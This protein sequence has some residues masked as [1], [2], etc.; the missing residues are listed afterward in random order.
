MKIRLRLSLACVGFACL[1]TAAQAQTGFYVTGGVGALWRQDYSRSTLFNNA[2][3]TTAQGSTATSYDP[4]PVFSL[5]VGWRV[6]VLPIRIEAEAGYG[7][8]TV[9]KA[10]I[11]TSD[12]AFAGL[13]GA[14]LHA[15]SGGGRDRLTA[16]VS[17]YYDLPLPGPVTPYVGAGFGYWR[18]T[19]ENTVFSDASGFPVLNARG[20]TVNNV[21]LLAEVGAAVR[22]V[23]FSRWSVAPAYRFQHLFAAGQPGVNEHIFKLAVRYDF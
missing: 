14:S 4:G 7:H 12:P 21:L 11:Q 1:S 13:N 2:F 15:S 20:T 17:A 19:S 5:G 3:G 8:Y 6:P 18:G 23:P 22:F 10:S 16:T 9:S